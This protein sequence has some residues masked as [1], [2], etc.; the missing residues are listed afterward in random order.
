MS[1]P[2]PLTEEK[3]KL[4]AEVEFYNNKGLLDLKI[5]SNGN[6]KECFT[7][8]EKSDIKLA[9]QGLLEEIEETS[10]KLRIEVNKKKN[11]N[12]DYVIGFADALLYSKKFIKKWFA[13]VVE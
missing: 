1:K 3:E 13:D 4:V 11:I 12:K 9:V 7:S 8:F 10:F 6:M 2:E 5:K